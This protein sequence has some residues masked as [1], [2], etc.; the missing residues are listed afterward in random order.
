MPT[1]QR[2]GKELLNEGKAKVV[3]RCPFTIQLTYA[4][5]EATQPIELGVDIGYTKIGFISFFE[6]YYHRL[7]NLKHV[8]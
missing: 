7:I 2:R 3:E 6:L 8:M 4:T 5:G 1:T